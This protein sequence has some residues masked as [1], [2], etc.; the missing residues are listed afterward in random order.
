MYYHIIGTD[1]QAAIKAL[2]NQKS[3]PAHYL[4]DQIH[5]IAM[6]VFQ[7]LPNNT[8]IQ[9][10]WTPGPLRLPSQWKSWWVSQTSGYWLLKYPYS[11]TSFPTQPTPHQCDSCPSN[12]SL[13]NLQKVVDPLEEIALICL[14]LIY[15]YSKS[16]SSNKFLKL[17]GS[18][19]C[20]QLAIL[21][22][23]RTG[24]IPLNHHLFCIRRAKMLLCPHCGN[25]IVKN[26]KHFLF[27][28]PHYQYEW[29]I[30]CR[31]LKRAANS[32]SYLLSN[33]SAIKPL[34]KFL[35][36]TSRFN[37]QPQPN[38]QALPHPSHWLTSFSLQAPPP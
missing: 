2:A 25:L 3:H 29:H 27:T 35:S 11:A 16:L 31:K 12:P 13:I 18:L 1:S 7:K 5:T 19:D 6:K 23:L 33:P 17:V 9:I 26:V 14:H 21:T 4:L 37:L 34:L 15:W 20:R 30:L 28:C 38:W 32:S 24:H 36:S 10:H 22:Q 8:S